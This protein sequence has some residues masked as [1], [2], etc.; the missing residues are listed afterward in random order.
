MGTLKEL[1][2][3]TETVSTPGG[4]LTVRGVALADVTALVSHH[5]PALAGLFKDVIKGKDITLSV[6]GVT[7][8]GMDALKTA[9]ELVAELIALAADEGDLESI[10]I[11]AKLPIPVQVE[12]VEKI[13]RLTF[14]MEGGLGKLVETVIRIAQGTSGAIGELNQPMAPKTSANGS[15]ASA[16]M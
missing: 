2:L 6:E 1:R 3:P 13:A 7:A 11:A 12:A 8:L 10:R 15:A 14:A 16:R 5:G 4:P 9:P